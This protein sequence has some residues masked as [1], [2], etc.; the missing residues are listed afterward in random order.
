[1]EKPFWVAIQANNFALSTEPS[2]AE[3][4]V[5]L[6]GYLSAL[7][8]FLRDEV[9]YD[10]LAHWIDRGHYTPTE[11][12]A[13]ADQMV[14]N[15]QTGL[16]EQGSD[17]VYLRA[18]SLLVL[19]ELLGRDID[20]PY[21]TPAQLNR[22]VQAA[23]AWASAEVDLRGFDLQ[24]GWIHTG[25]HGGDLLRVIG[26]HPRVTDLAGVLGAVAS[27]TTRPHGHHFHFDEDERLVTA[28]LAVL[29]RPELEPPVFERFLNQVSEGWDLRSA[30]VINKTGEPNLIN[31]VTRQNC[32][33]LLRS[34]YFAL[35]ERG[36]ERS[37]LVAT[38]LKGIRRWV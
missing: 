23:F 31:V 36:D 24:N 12:V 19:G 6:L 7:D 4:T 9:G 18:F 13:M 5:E 2:L 10:V 28:V 27:L 34:L 22:F 29:G 8:P 1:M 38:A 15:L 32:R 33:N 20:A 3:L 25:A 14:L 16:G 17:S 30:Q 35:L 21:L 37:T 11:M 26:K